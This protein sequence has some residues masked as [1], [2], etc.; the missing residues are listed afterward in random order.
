[1][2][3]WYVERD[4]HVSTIF[5]T[6]LI[7][8]L[9]C[10]CR[11]CRYNRSA[12]SAG[13][14]PMQPTIALILARHNPVRARTRMDGQERHVPVTWHYD[15]ATWP[16]EKAL[17]SSSS[18]LPRCGAP[19]QSHILVVAVVVLV[20][21]SGRYRVSS[22][23]GT[24]VPAVDSPCVASQAN[25]S[26][27]TIATL[28]SDSCPVEAL[29]L[30]TLFH[31]AMLPLTRRALGILLGSRRR[32]SIFLPTF[33]RYPTYMHADMQ[34]QMNTWTSIYIYIYIYI[35]IYRSREHDVWWDAA[36]GISQSYTRR[37]QTYGV[38]SRFLHRG[39]A[40]GRHFPL[41]SENNIFITL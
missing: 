1:M 35:D 22:S 24:S 33:A 10:S 38:L 17:V 29:V 41:S 12:A 16:N 34:A 40:E 32:L 14:C 19:L 36:S 7:Q 30:S 37:L 31:G 27:G 39:G 8:P 21:V 15:T 28:Q 25:V 4:V 18:L 5:L 23:R 13:F 20:V 11:Y 6:S 9:N 2:R 26:L 3:A